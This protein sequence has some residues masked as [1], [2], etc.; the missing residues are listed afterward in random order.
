VIAVG[1]AVEND[2]SDDVFL[3][4]LSWMMQVGELAGLAVGSS[5]CITS[6]FA[7]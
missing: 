2:D 6:I 3:F 5:V 4:W 1:F 7:G